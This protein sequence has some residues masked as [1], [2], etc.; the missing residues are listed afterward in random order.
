MTTSTSKTSPAKNDGEVTSKVRR[1]RLWFTD[2]SFVEVNPNRPAALVVFELEHDKAEPETV[3]ET[4][5]LL[6]HCLGRPGTVDEFIA[7]VDDYEP[8]DEERS[9]KARR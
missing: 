5:W 8:F 1:V 4:M 7:S 3:A 9:G 2:G 6:W